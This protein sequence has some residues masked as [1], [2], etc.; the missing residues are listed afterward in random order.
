MTPFLDCQNLY[1]VVFYNNF[2][3]QNFQRNGEKLQNFGVKKI[4]VKNIPYLEK[5]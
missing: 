5:K 4:G 1:T 3:F 2:L